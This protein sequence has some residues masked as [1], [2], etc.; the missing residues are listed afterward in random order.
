MDPDK[1]NFRE[2]ES[3]AKT[4]AA[5]HKFYLTL[6]VYIV[7][8]GYLHWL[9]LR[10]GIYNWAYWPTIG[11]TISLFWFAIAMLPS[12]WKERQIQ[13]EMLTNSTKR[14]S[15]LE[16]EKKY[17]I[18]E[19]DKAKRQVEDKMEFFTHLSIYI[20]VNSFFIYLSLSNSENF[21]AI[22]P[23][24]GWGIGVFFHGFKVFFKTRESNCKRKLIEK[25]IEKQ[26]RIKEKF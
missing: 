4:V 13:K 19:Y 3:A 25:E 12:R 26:R 20:L 18:R 11:F 2:Y 24:L 17:S 15:F 23:I 7:M 1:F 6:F 16:S 21:W 9:D 22:W 14:E 5:I 10:D 8:V